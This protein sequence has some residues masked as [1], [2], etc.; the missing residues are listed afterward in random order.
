M[1]KRFLNFI[2][3]FSLCRHYL[4]L[5]T[6]GTLH[7]NKPEY[8]SPSDG[9]NWSRVLENK[10]KM[11]K[12]LQQRQWQRQQTVETFWSSLIRGRKYPIFPFE[13]WLVMVLHLN[14]V[15]YL[16]PLHPWI[17]CVITLVEIS[18]GR[19]LNLLFCSYLLFEKGVV[20]YLNKPESPSPK[21]AFRQFCL[22]SA[23]WFW[24]KR[25]LN[26]VNVFSLFHYYLP[27]EKDM[28]PHF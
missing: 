19:F 25:F 12:S 10:I 22:K 7:L 2:N 13:D 6:A 17:L 9:W 14:K 11:R 18:P 27:L 26:F 5:K 24:R 28:F 21:D 1:R 20:F 23:Q 8:P 3:I 4:S 16:N 15:F